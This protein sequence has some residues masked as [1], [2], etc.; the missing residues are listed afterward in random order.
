MSRIYVASSWRNTYQPAIVETLRAVGHEVYDFKNPAPDNNGFSWRSI[1]GGWESWTSEQYREALRHPVAQAGFKSD[2][3]GMK[4]ADEFCLV[5]PC[6]RSA[7]LEAG[8]AMGAGKRCSVYIPNTE[9]IEP[10]L[11]YLLAGGMPIV[12]TI[13]GLIEFH[14]PPRAS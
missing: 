12:T 1:D 6:G 3:D 7:H 2:I 8:W 13:L 9:R 5:L 4:W 11:M 10:E 14:R